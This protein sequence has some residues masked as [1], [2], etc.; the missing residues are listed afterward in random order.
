MAENTIDTLELQI[1]STADAAVRS[2]NN[3]SRA[4]QGVN[5][6]LTGLNSHGL[7]SYAKGIGQVTAAIQ[8][9]NSVNTGNIAKAVT[10]LKALN[11]IPQVSDGLEKTKN[12]L[13]SMAGLDLKSTGINSTINALRR[14]AST[15]LTNFDTTKISGISDALSKFANIPDISSSVNRLVSSLAKLSASGGSIGTV[16]STLPVLGDAV[17]KFVANASNA[18]AVSG[19]LNTF[20]ASLAK[21]AT[22]GNK[23]GQTASQL[24]SLSQATLNFF[25]VMKNAPEISA[26]TLRM[27]EALAQLANSGSKANTATNMVTSGFNRLSSAGRGITGIGSRIAS[28]VSGAS[29]S[30]LRYGNTATDTAKKTGNLVSQLTSLYIK[31]FT[32]S[33]II[34][35]V[36]KSVS[37]ASDYVETLNY[38]NSAFDQV[39]DGLDTSGWEDAGAKSAEEYVGS[40]EKR[41]KELT[42]KLTGFEVSDA[43]DLMRSQ[44][45][46]LG[47]N[48]DD[49]MNYQATYAQ[50]A[51]SMGATAD[52]ATKLSQVLTEI[53]GDLAS[54]K[55]LDFNDVWQDMASGMVGM[56]RA[57]DKYGINIRVANLQQELYNLGIDTTVAKLNQSDKAILRTIVILN[58]SK[59]AWADLAETIDDGYELSFVA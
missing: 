21:L 18:G 27:T 56:S 44:S 59:Y 58:S 54:V 51:S 5:N 8:S 33:R 49:T 14:L 48:P 52:N 50:M 11:N 39:T 23:T 41:A 28:A 24:D 46:S 31:F 32:L 6:T 19:Q 10:Q 42:K 13:Q 20:I 45:D 1:S 35:S 26:N 57:L 22:A 15:D 37:S 38:F 9:L 43:G 12:A 3:M 40:F 4:L 47:L 7:R 53:G 17:S 30:L 55:N 29:N 25:N 16:T 34:K 36:W 2:I